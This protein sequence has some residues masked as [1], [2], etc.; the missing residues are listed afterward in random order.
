MR[1]ILIII[2]LVAT[3]MLGTL[4]AAGLK[5]HTGSANWAPVASWVIFIVPWAYM[6]ARTGGKR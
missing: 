4:F 2:A 3:A 6:F 5:E 1:A